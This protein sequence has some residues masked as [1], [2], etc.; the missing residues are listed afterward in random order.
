[1]RSICCLL[2]CNYPNHPT[3]PP[4]PLHSTPLFPL[5]HPNLRE[6]PHSPQCSQSECGGGRG[7]GGA[8]LTPHILSVFNVPCP[9]RPCKLPGS[10]R[11]FGGWQRGVTVL[12]VFYQHACGGNDDLKAATA[13]KCVENELEMSSAWNMSASSVSLVSQRYF[14][15]LFDSWKNKHR[16]NS[17]GSTLPD[18]GLLFNNYDGKLVF[19]PTSVLQNTTVYCT[20]DWPQ[21][22]SKSRQALIHK[23]GVCFQ[24]RPLEV[25]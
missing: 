12:S 7:V 21:K 4:H 25:T 3:P 23:A 17:W 14:I 13:G 10:Q 15:T 2:V 19:M 18:E 8:V 9:R 5:L 24:L 11:S 6:N 20:I 22:A 1:M 16:Q